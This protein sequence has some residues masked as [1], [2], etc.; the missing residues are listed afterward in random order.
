MESFSGGNVF[1]DKGDSGLLVLS[2][3]DNDV[4]GLF[5]VIIDDG[6]VFINLI[7]YVLN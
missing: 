5:F 2:V 4:V 7:E 3:E 6:S 1:V